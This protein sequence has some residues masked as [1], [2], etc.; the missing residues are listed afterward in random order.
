MIGSASSPFR[1]PK[2]QLE[3]FFASV[4]A[5]KG[6]AVKVFFDS[7]FYDGRLTA[8]F[9]DGFPY[10]ELRPR[11][12]AAVLALAG[13]RPQNQ[14][15]AREHENLD[16]LLALPKPFNVTKARTGTTPTRR[17]FLLRG[18]RSESLGR[19]GRS[20]ASICRLGTGTPNLRAR[21]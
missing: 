14:S 6:Y 21:G 19:R 1:I 20:S 12:A 7:G 11:Q 4:R 3:P 13:D 18:W 16:K 10:A 5:A 8:I 15:A 2:Y 9:R 17:V